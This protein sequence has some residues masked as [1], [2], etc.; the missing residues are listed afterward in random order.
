M[1]EHIFLY[2]E[3]GQMK[4][5]FLKTQ[6]AYRTLVKSAKQ[7]INFLIAQPKHMLWVLKTVSMRRFFLAPKTYI[8]TDG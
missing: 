4:T 3:P 7:K 8:K 6:N 1:T 2:A 5:R